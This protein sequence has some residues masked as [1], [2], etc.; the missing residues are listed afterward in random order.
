MSGT[1]NEHEGTWMHSRKWNSA[2]KEKQILQY[3]KDVSAHLK[4]KDSSDKFKHE[5]KAYYDRDKAEMSFIERLKLA[6]AE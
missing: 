6:E 2:A 5:L 3:M 1:E 4:T